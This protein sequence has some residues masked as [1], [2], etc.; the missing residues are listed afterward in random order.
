MTAKVYILTK[1][2]YSDY[3]IIGVE[4]DKKRARDIAKLLSDDSYGGAVEVETWNVGGIDI[5]AYPK[6]QYLYA[7]RQKKSPYQRHEPSYSGLY[8][9]QSDPTE[10]HNEEVNNVVLYGPNESDGLYVRVW[11]KDKDHAAKIAADL[12]AQHWAEQEN[13]T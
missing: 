9:D 1:G 11:A 3:G 2:N 8:V 5:S 10:S 13:I 12:F 4:T 6:G 7:V